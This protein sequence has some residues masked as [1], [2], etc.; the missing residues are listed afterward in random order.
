M[1]DGS[2][3]AVVIMAKAPLP[4]VCKTRLARHVGPERAAALYQRFLLD[5]IDLA[6]QVP[7]AQVSAVCP[8]AAHLGIL[9]ELLPEAVHVEVQEGEGLLAGLASAFASHYRRGF[10]RI[11]VVD[12]D[13]PTLPPERIAKALRLLAD[14]DLVLGPCDDG[15][16]FLI[17]ARAPRPELF[18]GVSYRGE[19]ICAQTAER[20]RD[21][22]LS[23][24]FTAPW[25][26]VDT[27]EDFDRLLAE[28]R[29]N[30]APDSEVTSYPAPRT[31]SFLGL[32]T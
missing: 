28:L 6:R 13:S 11:V 24:A 25:Y 32:P 27:R 9:R 5:T 10:R 14:H 1:D 26:D 12:G 20:G 4:G 22:G 8:D 3:D 19:T 31:R 7:G 30:G 2:T 23:V 16:Y 29:T 21:L 15:G 18:S 17:G